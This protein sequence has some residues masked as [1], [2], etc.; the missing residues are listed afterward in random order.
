MEAAIGAAKAARIHGKE[1]ESGQI[2]DISYT[3]SGDAVDWAFAEAGIKWSFSVE[4]RDL[5]T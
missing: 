2:C 4:L 1:F 5:G 3:S